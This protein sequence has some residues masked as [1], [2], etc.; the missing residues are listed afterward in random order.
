MTV[1]LSGPAEAAGRS[2]ELFLSACASSGIAGVA[3]PV[4]AEAGIRFVLRAGD[5]EAA[6]AEPGCDALLA[7]DEQAM[8]RA[9]TAR[10]LVLYDPGALP[11][12]SGLAHGAAALALPASDPETI[13]GALA[14]LADL[15]LESLAEAWGRR[16]RGETTE[17]AAGKIQAAR[18]AC[19]Q[20]QA[21]LGASPIRLPPGGKRYL[22]VSGAQALAWGALAAGC[23]CLAVPRSGRTQGPA[24]ALLALAARV[25]LAAHPASDEASA[26]GLAAGA[27]LAGARALADLTSGSLAAAGEMLRFCAETG[28]PAV[29]LAPDDGW[30]WPEDLPVARL[31]PADVREA[32]LMAAQAFNLAERHGVPAVV[33]V[34][35]A[36]LERRESLPGLPEDVRIER[37][38]R[39]V[40]GQDGAPRVIAAMSPELLARKKAALARQSPPASGLFC[41]PCP[42]TLEERELLPPADFLADGLAEVPCAFA[43]ALR[44]CAWA[45]SGQGLQPKDILVVAGGSCCL[46]EPVF[47]KTYGVRVPPGRALAVAAGAKLANPALTVTAWDDAEAVYRRGLAQLLD[48]ARLN[49]DLLVLL[50]SRGPEPPIDLL[51]LARQAGATF[52][53]RLPSA[54]EE[55]AADLVAQALSHKGFSL[56]QCPCAAG[57]P[58]AAESGILHELTGQPAFEETE[59]CLAAQGAPVGMALDLRPRLCARWAEELA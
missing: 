27:A 15:E 3:E 49:S 34:G 16:L 6:D 8:A 12:P 40:P 10:H 9:G 33:R 28:L 37:D 25:G 17:S 18:R 36:L 53:A 39:A 48:S 1:W 51:G 56:V 31:R 55:A 43:Q 59:P 29:V 23:T 46:P 52:L 32:F 44:L 30:S 42:A 45:W 20:A 47:P 26:L 58:V 24:A 2:A 57:G 50:W 4:A 54:D 41:V 22:N 38:S 11:E 13:A 5:A 14:W 7:L 35:A 19:E 21:K